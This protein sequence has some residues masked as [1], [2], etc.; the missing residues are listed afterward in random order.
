MDMSKYFEKYLSNSPC[1]GFMISV[2]FVSEETSRQSF[3]ARYLLTQ[4]GGLRYDKGF[5]VGNP[6]ELVDVSLIDKQLHSD[7][8]SFYS[9]NQP[10]LKISNTLTWIAP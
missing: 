5:Q 2:K 6:P 4:R 9:D 8:Y 7:L 3:H 10:D 1:K